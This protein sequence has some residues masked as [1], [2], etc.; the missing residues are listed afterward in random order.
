M[1]LTAGSLDNYISE[2]N[3]WEKTFLSLL[4][5]CLWLMTEMT[6]CNINRKHQKLTVSIMDDITKTQVNQ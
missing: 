4:Q 5:L 6:T 3:V 2:L 1:P